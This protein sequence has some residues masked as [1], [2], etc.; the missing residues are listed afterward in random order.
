MQPGVESVVSVEIDDGLLVCTVVVVPALLLPGDLAHL[1][2]GGVRGLA[3][4]NLVGADQIPVSPGAGIET[5]GLRIRA[6]PDQPFGGAGVVLA[7]DEVLLQ[8]IAVI[9]RSVQRF[10]EIQV[11]QLYVDL[12]PAGKLDL[13]GRTTGEN[14]YGRSLL[15]LLL[16]T[17]RVGRTGSY[18]LLYRGLK[19]HGMYG[20]HI[21]RSGKWLSGYSGGKF[22]VL[23]NPGDS[24]AAPYLKF[25][26]G[27]VLQPGNRVSK[28][29]RSGNLYVLFL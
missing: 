4:G 25:V 5:E 27:S 23:G 11:R 18:C 8:G 28:L 7:V 14:R 9:L 19:V 26:R 24:P 15:Y 20:G 1:D 6:D 12:L 10:R 2:A 16:F 21:G 3:R 22:T 13:A 29:L 17:G